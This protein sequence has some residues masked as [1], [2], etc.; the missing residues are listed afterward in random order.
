MGQAHG[1][2]MDLMRKANVLDKGY[3]FVNGQVLCHVS[4]GRETFGSWSSFDWYS[5]RKPK[6]TAFTTNQDERWRDAQLSTSRHSGSRILRETI[7]TEPVLTLSTATAAGLV[8]VCT[9]TDVVKQKS[10]LLHTTT[11]I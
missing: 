5:V 1:V 6:R 4:C 7:V 3:R 2:V 10:K 9:S 11:R 8:E